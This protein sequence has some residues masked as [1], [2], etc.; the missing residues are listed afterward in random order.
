VPV[1]M[2]REKA[3]TPR[4]KA[5]V[6]HGLHLGFRG[7]RCGGQALV[8]AGPSLGA[9]VVPAAGCGGERMIPQF[10]A[11]ARWVEIASGARQL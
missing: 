8:P 11:D 7:W 4:V 2:S 6:N 3:W 9:A 5:S 1:L 10:K